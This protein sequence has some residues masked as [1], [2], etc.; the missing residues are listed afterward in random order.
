MPE[1]A[2]GFIS[3]LLDRSSRENGLLLSCSL[4]HSLQGFLNQEMVVEGKVM[5]KSSATGIITVKATVI[6]SFGKVPR[7]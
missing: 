3:S 4:R 1:Y 7:R 2:S 5:G 6:D